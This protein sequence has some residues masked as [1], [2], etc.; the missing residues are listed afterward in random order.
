VNEY[1]CPQCGRLLAKASMI[2]LEIP[3]R[4]CKILVSWKTQE[5]V[6]VKPRA[7]TGADVKR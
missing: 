2:A 6:S 3:C 7:L 4:H 5:E 1:R